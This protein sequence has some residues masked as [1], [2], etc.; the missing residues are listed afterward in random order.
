[1]STCEESIRRNTSTWLIVACT[2][3]ITA[4]FTLLLFW[5]ALQFFSAPTILQYTGY[6][7]SF[8]LTEPEQFQDPDALDSLGELVRDG[9]LLSLDELWGFQSSFYQTII[10]V[11]I[12]INGLLAAFAFIFIKNSSHDKAIEAAVEHAQEHLTGREFDSLINDKV[13]VQMAGIRSDYDETASS[14]DNMLEQ[15]SCVVPTV[16]GNQSEIEIL[17]T[18][19]EELQRHIG[20]MIHQISML[21]QADEV[22]NDLEIR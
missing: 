13:E 9:T 12:A 21:D 2:S 4:V 14:L 19:L 11:L 8:V 22:G 6:A 18:K 3:G 15:F 5:C 17:N 7:E 10:T 20:V 1:M 16:E